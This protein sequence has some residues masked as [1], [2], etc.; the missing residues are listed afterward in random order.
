[1]GFTLDGNDIEVHVN[2]TGPWCR[3][4]CDAVL[5]CK[6]FVFGSVAAGVC[7]DCCWLKNTT[8]DPVPSP[9]MIS[10]LLSEVQPTILSGELQSKKAHKQLMT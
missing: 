2:T 6:A 10:Y 4:R 8:S 7:N 1:M 5:G 9:G 3:A